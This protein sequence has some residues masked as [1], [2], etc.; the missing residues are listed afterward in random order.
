MYYKSTIK[1]VMFASTQDDPEAQAK[2]KEELDFRA[3]GK[4]RRYSWDYDPTFDV[5]EY[6]LE[7]KEYRNLTKTKGYD[8]EG[9]Y[10][11]DGERVVFASNRQ[12]FEGGL[13]KEDADWFKMNKS[14]LME[15]YSMNAD[16]SDLKRLTDSDGYDGGPFYSHD[17]KKIC[18]RRFDR[19]GLTAEVYTMNADGSDQKQLTKLGAMSWAPYFHPSG[20]YLIFATNK[21]GFANF[22]LYLVDAKGEKEPVR[23]TH[24]E[25]LTG[26]RF[27]PRMGKNCRGRAIAQRKRNR[28]FSSRNGIMKRRSSFWES[29][30]GRAKASPVMRQRPIRRMLPI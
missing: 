2:Q 1:K 18:W 3:S 22:E 28:R 10:S 4:E 20:D 26:C 29:K 5:F 13:S 27:L 21:H 11:A 9:A 15:I 24:T 14:F 23:V 16:G 7:S 19:K 8:A 12:A 6:D 25:A 17:G 30:R